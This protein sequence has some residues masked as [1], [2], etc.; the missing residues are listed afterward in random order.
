[1]LRASAL[2]AF[3]MAIASIAA[4]ELQAAGAAQASAASARALLD[5]YCVTCHNDAQR[6][7]GGIPISLQTVDMADVGANASV[8]ENVVRKLRAGMMPPAGRP[9]PDRTAHDGLVSWLEAELDPR[10]R[11]APE[12]R[13]HGDLPLPE[14]HGVPQRHPRPAGA[15]CRRG[16]AAAGRRREL[17]LRQHRRRAAAQRVAHGALSGGGGAD[18]PDRGRPAAARAD[19][20]RVPHPGGAAAVRAGS[21]GCRSA[22][23]AARSFPTTSRRTASTSST[24]TCCAGLPANATVRPGSPTATSSR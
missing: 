9:R 19:R 2:I 3:W 1:M 15:G 18:Q 6:Q 17:R 14:P 20:A 11:R 24:W 8:W 23:A 10:R 13:P 7:R 12:P 16:G 21:R 4:G 22:R 5:R